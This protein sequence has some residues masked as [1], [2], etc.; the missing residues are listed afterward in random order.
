MDQ[1]KTAVRLRTWT[2]MLVVSY[3]L[4]T[5]VIVL[6]E[7]STLDRWPTYLVAHLAVAILVFSLRFAP[8]ESKGWFQFLRSWYPVP[9]ILVFYKEVELFAAA[10]GN[11]SLTD[12]VQLWET[13]LFDGYPHIYL[14]EKLPWVLFSEYIHFCYFFHNI[15]IL[16]I[17]G[18]FWVWNRL[19]FYEL[20]FLVTTTLLCSYLFYMF[21][22]VDSP[23]YLAP[24]LAKPLTGNFFYELVHF[25]SDRGGARGGAFPSSHVSVSV[26]VWL[27]VLFRARRWA[28]LLT[29]ITVGLIF[30]TVYGRF[31]YVL[32][33]VVGFA[34][35]LSI[36]G[37]YFLFRH[38]RG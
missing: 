1:L 4:L 37:T 35:A 25:V 26:T 27:V 32:D 33:S 20:I 14:S 28:Y 38:K 10:F 17:G 5:A 30:A 31:H 34:L 12:V 13:F 29:P 11:W 15:Q 2:D 16:L 9:L 23:F 24:D 18:L 22:P 8:W 19:A 3:L 21:F 7:R 6:V 36:A